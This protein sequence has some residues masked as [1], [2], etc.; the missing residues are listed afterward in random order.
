MACLLTAACTVQVYY[1]TPA[2]FGSSTPS[3]CAPEHSMLTA[4][5][6]TAPVGLPS[7]AVRGRSAGCCTTMLFTPDAISPVAPCCCRKLL[8]VPTTSGSVLQLPAASARCPS[9]LPALQGQPERQLQWRVQP[10]QQHALQR[11]LL[12][13]S[14]CACF[15]SMHIDCLFSPHQLCC[16]L[17][18]ATC[19][20]LAVLLNV[21]A[22]QLHRR[23][24]G[25]ARGCAQGEDWVRN[26]GIDSIDLASY[27]FYPSQGVL[28]R[29]A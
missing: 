1:G 11:C 5:R 6:L 18:A 4:G 7:N 22:A 23:Y 9:R 3:L 19:A 13:A 2:F 21:A 27:H 28:G 8:L 14:R 10:L 29:P 26:I 24:S 15:H 12:R 20:L 25:V 16:C 17:D